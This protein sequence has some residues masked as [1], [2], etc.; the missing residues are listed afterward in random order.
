MS[1][2]IKFYETETNMKL[3]KIQQKQLVNMIYIYTRIKEDI[4]REATPFIELKMMHL[5]IV[6]FL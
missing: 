5:F 6:I 3:D 1:G 4:K 2:T